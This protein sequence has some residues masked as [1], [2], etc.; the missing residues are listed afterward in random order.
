MYVYRAGQ[1]RLGGQLLGGQL[2]GGV[3]LMSFSH[4]RLGENY[5]RYDGFNSTA[6]SAGY[7]R[8]DG[9][10]RGFVRMMASAE[11]VTGIV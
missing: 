9:F 1:G 5:D 7:D 11:Y 4:L 10:S 3:L 8:Y 2:L 6:S